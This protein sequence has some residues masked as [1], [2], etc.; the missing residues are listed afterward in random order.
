MNSECNINLKELAKLGILETFHKRKLKNFYIKNIQRSID[1]K[2]Q[3]KIINNWKKKNSIRSNSELK[4]W[5]NLYE[6]NMEEWVNLI[7]SD[8][9]WTSWCMDKFK[10]ELN[11]HFINRKDY[12]DLYYYT[13]IKVKNKEIAD[14]IYI[15]IKEKESTFEEI[16]NNFSNDNIGFYA[17]KIGPVYLNNIEESVA[18][19]IKVGNLNQLFQPKS[20]NG[21]WLILRKD[22]VLRAELNH[23]QKIKLSLELGEKFLNKRFLE[24]QKN[25]QI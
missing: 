20:S 15:R 2:Q 17:K 21:F 13:I 19:L 18:S 5:L 25:K 22:N 12:L 7:N 1:E 16:V 14:E 4:S 3:L 11:Q 6:L 23:Q 9:L 8:Y 24:N 10:D